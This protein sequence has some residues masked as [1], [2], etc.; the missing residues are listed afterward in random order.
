MVLTL[1]RKADE[2]QPLSRGGGGFSKEE[3]RDL[4]KFN[5]ATVCDTVEVLQKGKGIGA[6]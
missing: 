2:Y 1:T 6:G 3:L 4:F 5:T